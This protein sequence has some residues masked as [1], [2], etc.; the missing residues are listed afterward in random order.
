M[1]RFAGVSVLA[2]LIVTAAPLAMRWWIY[3]GLDPAVTE[4][5]DRMLEEPVLLTAE[6]QNPKPLPQQLIEQFQKVVDERTK[7]RR[8]LKQLTNPGKLSEIYEQATTSRTSPD[9]SVLSDALAPYQTLLE[10]S[11][12]L[13]SHPDYSCMLF[14][15]PTRTKSLDEDNAFTDL[16]AAHALAAILTCELGNWDECLSHSMTLFRLPRELLAIAL[17]DEFAV[18]APYCTNRA[19]QHTTNAALLHTVLESVL[20]SDLT[21]S[22]FDLFS[23]WQKAVYKELRR[24]GYPITL[25]SGTPLYYVTRLVKDART[26][27]PSWKLSKLPAGHHDYAYWSRWSRYA[28][29]R[30]LREK[31]EQLTESKWAILLAPKAVGQ[32]R[33][34]DD[35]KYGHVS[36]HLVKTFQIKR[37]LL[38]LNIAARL[39]KLEENRYPREAKDLMPK[40]LP[41]ELRDSLTDFATFR[42]NADEK[43]FYSI[44]SDGIEDHL[45]SPYDPNYNAQGRQN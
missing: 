28:I 30:D 6:H 37:R 42:W 9:Q 1:D 44:G 2:A 15:S 21:S 14:F 12:I 34:A 4:Q 35:L 11:S 32:L 7:V 19:A 29:V 40:Y 26:K 17:R 10:L 25:P 36:E 41:S 20:D 31:K 3:Q 22:R 38:M 5:A 23:H 8:A 16:H 18:T 43:A 39:M 33:V 24:E 13:A 45:E 27:F